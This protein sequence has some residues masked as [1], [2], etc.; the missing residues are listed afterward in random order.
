MT[1]PRRRTSSGD[2]MIIIQ[3][4]KILGMLSLLS[5]LCYISRA[6]IVEFVWVLMVSS[7]VSYL[8]AINVFII[9][10]PQFESNE[11]RCLNA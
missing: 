11:A 5:V 8:S 10:Q 1:A 7:T 2:K 9:P 6:S 3:L 4:I